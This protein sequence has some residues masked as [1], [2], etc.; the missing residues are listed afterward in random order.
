LRRILPAPIF[1][2]LANSTRSRALPGNRMF[3]V[4]RIILIVAILILVG[5]ASSKFSARLGLPVLVL[6]LGVGMLAG[7]EGVGG[8]EFENYRLAHGIGSVA[9]AIILFDGGLRTTL[10]AFRKVLA[11][12][13][14]LAT[15]GVFIT[16]GITGLAASWITGVPLLLG[17]LLGS[18]VGSTDAAAVFAVLRSKGLNLRERL[19][20][21]LEVESASNDPMA[22]FLTVGL[23]Q[24]LLGEIELGPGLLKLFVL[25]MSVGAIVGVAIGVAAVWVIN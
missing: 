24:V 15:V 22:I 14:L 1:H 3:A 17:L 8:I 2:G 20:A 6:F 18:I 16:A 21:L 19:S 5:I 9:L 7:S 4:D 13:V 12:S 11:P 25:Q 23:L 10:E